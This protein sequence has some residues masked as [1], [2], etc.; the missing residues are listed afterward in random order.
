MDNWRNFV[1]KTVREAYHTKWNGTLQPETS[2]TEGQIR[3]RRSI[4]WS[5]SMVSKAR[6]DVSRNVQICIRYILNLCKNMKIFAILT[7]IMK[8]QATQRNVITY[9]FTRFVRVPTVHHTLMLLC[10][11]SCLSSNGLFLN[12]MLLVGP[13]IQ[14]YLYSI[15]L[16]F[17]DSQIELTVDIAKKCLQVKMNQDDR[18]LQRILWWKSDEK[19][20]RSWELATATQG[21]AVAPFVATRCLQ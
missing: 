13:T 18:N 8:M 7:R 21:T 1:W 17:R 5:K 12:N 19:P 16:R 20:L 4:C 6:V 3:L 11:V 15:V 14:Q 2:Y 9:H 10:Y